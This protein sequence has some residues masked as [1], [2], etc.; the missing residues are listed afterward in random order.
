[1]NPMKRIATSILLLLVIFGGCKPAGEKKPLAGKPVRVTIQPVGAVDYK[2]PVRATGLLGTSTEMKLSFKTGGIVDQLHAREGRSVSRGDVLAV[3]DL[4]E[5]RA[6]VD[7]ANIGLEKAERDMNRAKNLY[8]D[9]VATLEQYQNAISAF[10][11]AKA[12]QQIADFNLRHSR[13][14]APSDGKIQKVLV[15]TNEVIGAGYPA[16]LFASTENDW[17]VRASLTDKD[18]VKLSIGDSSRIFMD[19]FPGTEFAAEVTELASVADPVTGT[20]EVELLILHTKPQFRTGFI[21]RAE[22]YPTHFSHS[23]VVPMEALLD[24][25]DRSAHVFVYSD[26]KARKRRITTG[27]ILGERVVVLEGLEEGEMV[28]TEG[29]KFLNSDT[30]VIP[31]NPPDSIQP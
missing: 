27:P 28:V 23:L 9:S 21:S 7:Q 29:A 17:V 31:V 15:E 3:L 2:I 1:M 6:Q 11:L 20:Y 5:I 16:I 19:A 24:A 26:G 8:R 25:G 13:I 14:K 10:E 12:Q 22:I 18:I 4:S 30:E